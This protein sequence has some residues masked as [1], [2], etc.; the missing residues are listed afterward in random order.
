MFSIGQSALPT[1]EDYEEALAGVPVGLSEG[2]LDAYA[3]QQEDGRIYNIR[4]A[5]PDQIYRDALEKGQRKIGFHAPT[6]A[7]GD[8]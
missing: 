3:D 8:F 2:E 1:K 4:T 5:P 7:T 6:I